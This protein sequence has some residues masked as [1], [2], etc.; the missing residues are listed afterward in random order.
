MASTVYPKLQKEGGSPGSCVPRLTNVSVRS[1]YNYVLYTGIYSRKFCKHFLSVDHISGY[2]VVGVFMRNW[3]ERDEK[4]HC[5][6]DAEA[7]DAEWVCNKLGI[8]F[9]EV[10]FVKEYWNEVFT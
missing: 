10:N 8:P 2:E 7:E 4:G 9:H 1:L 5:S 6:N 3:D